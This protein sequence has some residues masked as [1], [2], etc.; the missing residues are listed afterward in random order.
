MVLVNIVTGAN[1]NQ[2]SHHWGAP[3]CMY[4]GYKPF[5]NLDAHI[6]LLYVNQDYGEIVSCKKEPRLEPNK[7]TKLWIFWVVPSPVFFWAKMKSLFPGSSIPLFLFWDC[8]FH[9]PGLRQVAWIITPRLF[10]VPWHW[11]T[12][13]R[14]LRRKIAGTRYKTRILGGS[15]QES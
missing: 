9:C 15:S 14:P 5:T 2:R 7:Y 12:E 4:R 11:D 6:I 13:L 8:W 10:R 3:P 1:L